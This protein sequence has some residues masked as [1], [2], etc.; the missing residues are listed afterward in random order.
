M[1]IYSSTGKRK[2]TYALLDTGS[3]STLISENFAAELKLHGNKTEIK[4]SNKVQGVRISNIAINKIFEAKDL[5]I[6]PVKKFN[7]TSQNYLGLKD[8]SHLKGLKLA[9]IRAED[10]KVLIGAGIPKAFHQLDIKSRDKREPIAIK[11][12]FGWA[13]FDSKCVC[14]SNIKQIS[15]N[16]LSISSEED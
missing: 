2:N 8:V 10:I 14:K 12:P 3:Q 5:F 9:D 6:I 4:M 11:T 1:L 16:C 15:V 13:V 7:M